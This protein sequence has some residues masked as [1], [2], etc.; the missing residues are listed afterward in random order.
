MPPGTVSDLVFVSYSHA[1]PEWQDKVLVLLKPFVRQGQLQ[2]WADPYIRTGD[3]WRRNIDEALAR[4]CVGV[5][6]LTPD[7]L[8]SDFI[9]EVE[10]PHLLRAARAGDLT[11]V[12]VP[13]EPYVEGATRFAEGDLNDFQ[14]AW[15]RAE[16]IAELDDRRRPRALVTV[17][18]HPCQVAVLLA[19]ESR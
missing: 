1:N 13:V 17:V 3:V 2:V 11:L 4:T 15:T 18:D 16:P 10:L 9:S 5:V 8:A 6:L 14:W 7:L 12:V 19:A